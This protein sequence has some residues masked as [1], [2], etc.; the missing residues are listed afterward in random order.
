MWEKQPW[1]KYIKFEDF[2]EYIL[3]YRVAF[4]PLSEWR[5]TYAEA[6]EQILDSLFIGSDV[7]Q[8]YKLINENIIMKPDWFFTIRTSSVGLFDMS[9]EYMWNNRI[10]NCWN[11][12]YF[13]TY[14]LRSIGI[15]CGVD[16]L[17]QAPKSATNHCWSFIVDTTGLTCDFEGGDH[18]MP[19]RDRFVT[20]YELK[21]KIYRKMFASQKLQLEEV[22]Q[23]RVFRFLFLINM[24]RMYQ[25]NIS[26]M[27]GL[28]FDAKIYPKGPILLICVYLIIVSG[29]R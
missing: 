4:E 25:V 5:E 22:N 7:L 1:G 20:F 3:P 26:P 19:I 8:A 24:K 11:R 9:A 12:T 18:R 21:G 15:P 28:Q 23:E 13:T 17:K 16:Y 6:A 29:F 14:L 2:C 10:G 27:K